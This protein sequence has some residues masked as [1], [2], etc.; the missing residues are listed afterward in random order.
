MLIDLPGD[1]RE[2]RLVKLQADPFVIEQLRSLLASEAAPGVLDITEQRPIGAAEPKIYS[3]LAADTIVGPFWIDRLI[4]R[5]GMGEVYLAHRAAADFEQRV[6]LKM[7]RPEAIGRVQMFD[8][9]RRLLAGLEH[10]GI[11]RL[12]DGGLASDGRPYMA[13]EYVEGREITDWCSEHQADLPTRLRLFLELCGAVEYAHGHLVLHLDIKPSN[14]MIDCDGR[15]RLLD[16]GV[17]KIVDA[18]VLDRTMTQALLTPGYAAPEQFEGLRATV[19]TDVYALGAVL[20]ELLAGRGP[21]QFD[22]A[23]L[24]IVL[25]RLLHDDPPYPSRATQKGAI[26]STR[27]QGDLDAIVM[28]AMRRNPGD[29]YPGVAAFAGD[30]RRYLAFKPVQARAGTTVYRLGRFLRRNRWTA[31]ATAMAALVLTV[32]AGGIAWQARRTAVERDVA[33]AEAGRLEAVNQAFLLMFRDTSDPSQ[34]KSITVREMIDGT[35]KRLMGS[36]PAQSPDIAAMVGALADLYLITENNADAKVLLERAL[37]RGVARSDPVGSARLKLKLGTILIGEG[38]LVQGQRLL[39]EARA[40][41]RSDPV[42]FRR[43]LVETVGADAHM[44]RQQGRRKEAIALLVNDMAN[45]ERAYFAYS[46]DLQTR[47]TQV[48]RYL[49]EEGRFAEA[50]SIIRQGLATLTRRNQGHS[51]AA[52]SLLRAEADIAARRGDNIA[53]ERMMHRTVSDRRVMYGRSLELAVDLLYHGR[54]LNQ[55]GRPA[56]ALAALDEAAPMAI[57][58]FGAWSRP[59]VQVILARIEALAS[60]GRVG[61]ASSALTQIEPDLR[62]AGLQSLD[63]GVYLRTRG[64]IRLAERRFD[65]CRA[66][67]DAADVIFTAKASA[68]EAYKARTI[69]I[70]QQLRQAR[71]KYP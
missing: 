68:G 10:P 40:M 19:A 30:V 58:H 67:L 43:E 3:S 22:N 47:Y 17:A 61:D 14:I 9:E 6:A 18:A 54:L 23:P 21:W 46:R 71:R 8:A 24:P 69:K 48:S 64:I 66:D 29:R 59:S 4:G 5:G 56:E 45:A 52:I 31:V 36:L 35:T 42:R 25:R 50:D 53:A 51:S 57:E 34:F 12:I 15:V 13:L 55:M 33:Q 70:R 7:L 16:F 41:W 11:A 32:G 65:E 26:S 38:R 1:V 60:L 62:R 20:F 63:Y 27:L 2:A 37:A 28:K 44:L 39:D 49:I